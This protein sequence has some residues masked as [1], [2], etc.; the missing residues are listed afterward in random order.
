M[1]SEGK[2]FVSEPALG[3]GEVLSET[4]NPGRLD[5]E[6]V[7]GWRPGSD[8]TLEDRMKALVKLLLVVFGLTA[9]VRAQESS[10]T[11][12]TVDEPALP[13]SKLEI[14]HPPSMALLP[15]S[16][17]LPDPTPSPTS[18]IY[19]PLKTKNMVVTKPP[20]RPKR[21]RRWKPKRKSASRSSDRSPCETI[22]ESDDARLSAP[23]K[24]GTVSGPTAFAS[25][26]QIPL[27]RIRN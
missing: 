6:I 23:P 27:V 21:S 25:T 20:L 15:E 24:S 18:G 22:T 3:T 26:R 12:N 10:P 19:S 8:C 2:N 4:V 17:A 11:P 13:N 1:E 16:G 7:S 9:S 14:P 5:D